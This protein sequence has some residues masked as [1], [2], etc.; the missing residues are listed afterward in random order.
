MPNT[1]WYYADAQQD[2][3]GPFSTPQLKQLFAQGDVALSSLVWRAGMEQWLS[4][5]HFAEELAL[6]AANGEG[7]DSS[8]PYVAPGSAVVEPVAAVGDKLQAYADVVGNNFDKYRKKWR[9]DERQPSAKDTWHWPAF[10]FGAMWMFYRKMYAIGVMWAGGSLLLSAMLMLLGVPD[11]VASGI[12]IG[13]AAAAGGLG[14]TFYLKHTQKLIQQ[15]SSANAGRAHS[16][17]AELR[18]RGGTSGAAV[19]VGNL[20]MAGLNQ[21]IVSMF[22]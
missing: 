7:G 12:S 11:L 3:K 10:F 5:R 6:P 2:R 9:L 8:N 1:Q 16:M 4:L 18:L 14:N 17:R 20:V 15:V 22:L 13:I 21:L 19:V